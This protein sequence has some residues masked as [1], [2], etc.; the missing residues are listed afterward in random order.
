M[1]LP[2][3]GSSTQRR[4]VLLLTGALLRLGVERIRRGA[5]PLTL[6][7]NPEAHLHH[8]TLASIWSIIERI[9]GQKVIAMHSGALLASARLSSVRRLTRR[10]GV[11]MER[12]V[13]EGAINAEL[14]P[15]LLPSA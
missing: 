1:F 14:R 4:G 2:D 6:L 15:L 3:R 11:V 13:P 9:G 12:R 10:D 7:E 5:S 8:M